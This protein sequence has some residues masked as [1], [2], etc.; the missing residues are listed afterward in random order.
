MRCHL[1]LS[2]LIFIASCTPV[3]VWETAETEADVEAINRIHE[4]R[5]AAF[6]DGDVERWIGLVA[7]DAIFMPMNAPAL[8]GR[9]ALQS[10]Y[11]DWFAQFIVG[12]THSAEEIMVSGDLA[13]AR[14]TVAITLTPREGGDVTQDERK[15]IEIFQRQ[16]D[17]SWKYW[18]AIWNSDNPPAG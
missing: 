5:I 14:G 18:R 4:E 3:V 10:F 11:V 17:G 1:A 16:T 12:L 6:N 2:F 15:Y 8:V 13:F 7:E 9:D